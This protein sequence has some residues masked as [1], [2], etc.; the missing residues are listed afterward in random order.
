MRIR[1]FVFPLILGTFLFLAL[2]GGCAGLQ[3]DSSARLAYQQGKASLAA[4]DFGAAV[5]HFQQA[6]QLAPE[7]PEAHLGLGRA[8]LNDGDYL[9]AVPPL[10]T[11]Y[12]LSPEKVRDEA[13]SM[14]LDAIIG[15]AGKSLAAGDVSTGLKLLEEGA[16]LAQP[17]TPG[18]N[19]LLSTILEGGTG[20]I[21][22]GNFSGAAKVFSTALQA[23]PDSL[24]AGQAFLGMARAY[25]RAGNYSQAVDAARQALDAN[26]TLGGSPMQLLQRLN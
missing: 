6:A 24:R 17:G 7:W 3:V 20:L 12:Q 15:G 19:A 4:G 13:A 1:P 8:F 9:K 16:Q 18:W 25:V 2:L 10:R 23:N 14:L 11:A 5:N 22:S 26:P 21:T